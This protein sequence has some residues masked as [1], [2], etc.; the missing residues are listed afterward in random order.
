MNE[1][2][3]LD[4]IKKDK[5]MMDILRAAE[6]LR[7]P[8]WWIGA[9]FVRSKVWD[10]LHGYKKRTPLPDIDLIYFDK[11]DFS[12]EEAESHS[13]KAEDKYQDMLSRLGLGIKWSVTNQARMHIYHK[14]KPY[15]NSEEALSEWSET[16]TCI[17]VRL[18]NGRIVL[19]TP[20]G[21]HD[22]VKG[23]LRPT[24][25]TEKGLETFEKRIRDKK[26]LQKWPKLRI[27]S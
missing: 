22:L 20:H 7:L 1:Q 19:T 5:W 25:K 10:H 17:G 21:I 26:W 3:I 8:D 16:A 27:V 11:K 9:G 4:L 14:R 15:K 12:K 24:L 13:T 23:I 18:E 2:D 6:S